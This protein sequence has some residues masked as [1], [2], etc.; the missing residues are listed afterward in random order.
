MPHWHKDYA[1]KRTTLVLRNN[2][3][4]FTVFV[5]KYDI[6]L[7]TDYSIYSSNSK[8]HLNHLFY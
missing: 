1:Y 4:H 8:H 3:G 2:D 7:Q 5:Q 6:C